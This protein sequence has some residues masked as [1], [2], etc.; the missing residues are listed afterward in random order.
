MQYA[1]TWFTLAGA[2][3]IAFGV[4]LYGQHYRCQI[5]LFQHDPEK[6][7]PDFQKVMLKI[8]KQSRMIFRRKSSRSRDSTTMGET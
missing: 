8:K 2:V 7:T 5:P 4:W 1:I 3:V 6:W